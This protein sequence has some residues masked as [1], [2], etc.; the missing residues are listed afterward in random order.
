MDLASKKYEFEKILYKKIARPFFFMFDPELMHN[1]FIKL[2]SILG[3]SKLTK[4]ITSLFFESKNPMLQQHILGLNF[5]NPVGLAAGFDKNGE[6]IS[7]MEDVGFGFVEAGSITASPCP[8]NPGKRFERLVK[9][10]TLWVHFG[11]NNKGAVANHRRIKD[12]NFRFPLF[13]SAAKTNSKET[14]E[15]KAG[16]NDYL[17]TIKTFSN[18]ADAFVLNISCPN[19]HGGCS[20]SEAK[21][22]EKLI[23]EVYKLKLKQ[24]IFVK[25]S[26]DLSDK[27]LDKII[28]LSAKYN[29]SGFICTNL[30][31]KHQFSKGGL[32]GKSIEKRSDEVLSYVY[33]KANKTNKKGNRFVIIGVGGI[34]NAEDAYKKIKLGANLVQLITGL[35]YEGPQL[36]GQINHDL[37]KLLKKDG[38][39]NVREAV[40]VDN[41]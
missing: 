23:K 28:S 12:K 9:Q 39:K 8:G 29:V 14:T 34:F 21:S 17:F 31:K 2:G 30:S 27:E 26:P 13:I 41:K 24:P 37:V 38:Y 15:E 7:I 16:I 40:G 3:S 6:M 36:I 35:V 32:S 4:F 33:K 1:V 20:F 19:A 11:L 22:F 10:N 25:I 5:R 18:K